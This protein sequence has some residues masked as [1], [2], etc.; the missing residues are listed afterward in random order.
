MQSI[1]RAFGSKHPCIQDPL[2]ASQAC[3]HLFGQESLQPG[4]NL[5]ESQPTNVHF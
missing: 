5:L 2:N 1:V 4:E 3:L